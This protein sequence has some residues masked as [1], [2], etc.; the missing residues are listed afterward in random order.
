MK[1]GGA[2]WQAMLPLAVLGLCACGLER[3]VLALTGRA[4]QV[5]LTQSD[6]ALLEYYVGVR[7]LLDGG[8][9]LEALKALETAPPQP[10]RIERMV[11][12]AA[13]QDDRST[14]TVYLSIGKAL[15]R[16]A[17]IA[18]WKG[19]GQRATQCLWLCRSLMHRVAAAPNPNDETRDV[20]RRLAKIAAVAELRCS[21]A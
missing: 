17:E 7:T 10:I 5:S 16:M 13:I 3:G 6:E 12:D 19:D 4:Q 2:I 14:T 9:E 20:A 18:A 8:K 21:I 1:S 11:G 15:A